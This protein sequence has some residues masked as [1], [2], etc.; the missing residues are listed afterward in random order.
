MSQG[1]ASVNLLKNVSDD[2]TISQ[3]VD[4]RG[5]TELVF[6]LS[7]SGTTSGGV[8]TLEESMPVGTPGDQVPGLPFSGSCSAITTVNAST[9]TG[10][11][12]VAVHTSSARAYGWVRARVST[13]I[14]GGGTISVG[15]VAV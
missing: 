2:E 6:Y 13:A 5:R 3:W 1:Y 14:S 12:Q 11:A 9:F 10:D 15:L 7:S 8:V 4:V